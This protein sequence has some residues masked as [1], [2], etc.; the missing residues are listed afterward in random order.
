MTWK[1]VQSSN[2]RQDDR[3]DHLTQQRKDPYAN[4]RPPVSHNEKE[5]SKKDEQKQQEKPKHVER[6]IYCPNNQDDLFVDVVDLKTDNSTFCIEYDPEDK[7]NNGVLSYIGS[8]SNLKTMNPKSRE[9]SFKILSGS[10]ALSDASDFELKHVGKVIKID[11][12]WKILNAIEIM[13][14]K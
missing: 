1:N 13:L 2:K 9:E 10:C 11:G 7:S 14:K 3:H 6:T 5:Q 12:A 8:L 4:Q